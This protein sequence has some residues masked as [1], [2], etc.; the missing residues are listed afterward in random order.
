MTDVSVRSRFERFPATVKGAMVFRGEDADPHQ[1]AIREARVVG[2]PG[3]PARA[4]PIERA[5]VT[6]PPHQDVF[7]P[8][9]MGIADLP[10]GW[11]GFEIDV[12]LDGSPRTL[13]GD[14]RF[15]IPWPRGSMRTGTVRVDRDVRVGSVAIRVERVQLA[16]D[17]TSVRFVVTPP[18][19]AEVVVD[20]A[21]GR[22]SLPMLSV[23]V[24]PATGQGTATG[25][26]LARSEHDLRVSF[27]ADDGSRADLDIALE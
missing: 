26:P 4:L 15:T 25:Y 6:V 18:V 1:V 13:H 14:R 19:D 16:S 21:D 23:A 17:S 9:E 27:L 10:P 3:E 7:V 22:G 8:F 12:D 20:L 2:V 24:E 5:T 11:Y